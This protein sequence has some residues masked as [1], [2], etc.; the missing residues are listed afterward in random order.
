MLHT[1]RVKQT[2]GVV[3]DS[4]RTREREVRFS[5]NHNAEI[6]HRLSETPGK[7]QQIHGH[8]LQIQ[9]TFVGLLPGPGGMAVNNHGTQFEF[10]AVKRAFRLYIDEDYDH[11]LLLNRADKLVTSV[12]FLGE[13]IKPEDIY[14]GLRQQPGDPTVENIAGWI[15]LWAAETF[16]ADVACN[17]QETKTNGAEQMAHWTGFE[18][19]LVR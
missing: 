8:G 17:V 7:C 16:H 10:G 3:Q 4:T 1:S 14:P 18:G 5:V 13:G 15:A 11:K 19:K 12:P 6:A 9:L 2:I